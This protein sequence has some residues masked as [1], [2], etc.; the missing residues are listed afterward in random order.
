MQDNELLN[1]LV[2]VKPVDTDTVTIEAF[3]LDV[4]GEEERMENGSTKFSVVPRVVTRTL[5]LEEHENAINDTVLADAADIILQLTEPFVVGNGNIT[6]DENTDVP[7]FWRRVVSRIR[8]AQNYVAVAGR[9]GPARYILAHS[10]TV[11]RL[12]REEAAPVP[13]KVPRFQTIV[14]DRFLGMTLVAYDGIPE[15]TILVGRKTQ[16]TVALAIHSQDNRKYA[17]V[18][19]DEE[20]AKK[21]S[22]KFT[23]NW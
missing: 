9:E 2:T 1:E 18:V 3:V 19:V 20:H 7:T 12:L 15:D 21:Q 17:F 13:R 11:N 4:T 16:H 23:V 22:T 14:E 6:R 8:N 10:E 5:T